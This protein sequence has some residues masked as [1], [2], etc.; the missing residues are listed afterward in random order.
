LPPLVSDARDFSMFH[1]PEFFLRAARAQQSSSGAQESPGPGPAASS[2]AKVGGSD[3]H[4]T[5]LMVLEQTEEVTSKKAKTADEVGLQVVED[6]TEDGLVVIA[7]G[8]AVKGKVERVDKRG[9]WMKGGGLI[10]RVGAV[11]T[12]TGEELPVASTLGQKGDKRDVKGVLTAPLGMAEAIPLAPI[13]WAVMPFIKG[14]HYVMRSG[15]RYKLEVTLPPQTDRARLLAAQPGAEP[16]GYATVYAPAGVWCG[17]VYIGGYRKVLLRPGTY[18]CRIE[19]FS[20]QES[21][22]DFVLSGGGA[23]HLA[24][25]CGAN[26]VIPDAIRLKLTTAAE[27]VAPW[28]SLIY[29]NPWIQDRRIDWIP[30]LMPGKTVDLTK[31]DPEVFRRLPPFLR[32]ER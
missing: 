30:D 25:D 22:V 24:V 7:K 15:T 6:V 28:N 18:S 32:V 13:F 29:R 20:P 12:V 4:P 21:Y 16:A 3:T 17:G 27:V 8:T 10:V 19:M 31:I 2:A 23:Y 1:D 9:S 5:T 26:C 11:R 14:N